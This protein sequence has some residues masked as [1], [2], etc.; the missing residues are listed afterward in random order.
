MSIKF[1]LDF[2]KLDSEP[3]EKRPTTTKQFQDFKRLAVST[4]YVAVRDLLR[5][6]R[7]QHHGHSRKTIEGILAHY[8]TPRYRLR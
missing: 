3:I 8:A 6:S 1:N 2:V 4:A 7:H 5:H